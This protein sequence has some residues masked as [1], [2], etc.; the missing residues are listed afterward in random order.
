MYVSQASLLCYDPLTVP[1]ARQAGIDL[2]Q[3]TALGKIFGRRLVPGSN[4][5]YLINFVL[6]LP[7]RPSKRTILPPK[8][9]Y[10]LLPT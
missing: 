8:A 6:F 9:T 10:L 3:G 2:D 7:T 1:C 4:T 5:T